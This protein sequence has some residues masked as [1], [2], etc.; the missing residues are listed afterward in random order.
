[1]SNLFPSLET[2]AK[3]SHFVSF[4]LSTLWRGETLFPLRVFV[5]CNAS[6]LIVVVSQGT[7]ATAA[8]LGTLGE[9]SPSLTGYEGKLLKP[10]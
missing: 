7:A 8:G 1:M 5:P 4:L 9:C 6:W 2:F 3:A 10:S